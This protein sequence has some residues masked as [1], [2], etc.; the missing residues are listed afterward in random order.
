MTQ[1]FTVANFPIRMS[2]CLK[3]AG[4]TRE[5]NDLARLR[6]DFFFFRGNFIS[7][8]E[9]TAA[10]EPTAEI[11]FQIY[12]LTSGTARHLS[13]RARHFHC[14]KLKKGRGKIIPP[15][16]PMISRNVETDKG[17]SPRP[18]LP[19]KLFIFIF[20]L[21]PVETPQFPL[22]LSHGKTIRVNCLESA[23]C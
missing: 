7:D 13:S 17:P 19:P 4:G 2:D 9:A 11:L 14:K 21:L 10:S 20:L 23:K 8:C 6:L 22:F 3:N 1:T 12:S 16:F 5:S 18:F 15:S